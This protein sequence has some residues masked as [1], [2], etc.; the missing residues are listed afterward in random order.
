MSMGISGDSILVDVEENRSTHGHAVVGVCVRMN[1]RNY[2]LYVGPQHMC[3]LRVEALSTA[4]YDS[5]AARIRHGQFTRSKYFTCMR[6]INS[7]YTANIS[8]RHVD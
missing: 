1:H 3:E 6:K 4:M 8:E 2:M 7:Q 5:C